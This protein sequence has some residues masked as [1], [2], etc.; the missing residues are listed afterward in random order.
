[1][2]Y[3]D[4]KLTTATVVHRLTCA[5]ATSPHAMSTGRGVTG[6]FAAASEMVTTSCRTMPLFAMTGHSP[7]KGNQGD[8]LCH[9][10]VLGGSE[11]G[12]GSKK[13]YSGKF[14]VSSVSDTD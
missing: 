1:M 4:P 6:Y 13:L 8:F 11:A 14:R 10:V 2:G 3:S 12:G 7:L 5:I 9:L